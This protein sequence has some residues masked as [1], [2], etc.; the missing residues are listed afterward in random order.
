MSGC[1]CVGLGLGLGL[2][3]FFL[4]RAY[5]QVVCIAGSDEGLLALWDLRTCRHIPV[6][7]YIE[8]TLYIHIRILI[9]I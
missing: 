3:L 5:L 7:I 6:L 2:G 8:P 4:M 1:R 9:C